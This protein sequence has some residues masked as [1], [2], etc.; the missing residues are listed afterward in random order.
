MVM[1]LIPLKVQGDWDYFFVLFPRSTYL[2]DLAHLRIVRDVFVR[3][4][5]FV[6]GSFPPQSDVDFRHRGHARQREL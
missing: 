2:R 6:T 3:K 5:L 4:D 1:M